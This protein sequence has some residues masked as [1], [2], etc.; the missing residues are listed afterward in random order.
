[1]ALHLGEAADRP[2]DVPREL[3]VVELLGLHVEAGQLVVPLDVRLGRPD[4]AEPFL[5]HAEAPGAHEREG[6]V[7]DGIV[8]VRELPVE[9]A[10]E[11]ALVDD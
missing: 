9:D 8:E 10:D 6:E 4:A 1:V 7:A 3:P 5:R 2:A 11:P